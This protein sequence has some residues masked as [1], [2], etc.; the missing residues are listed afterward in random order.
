L[1]YVV[2]GNLIY[3]VHH[4]TIKACNGVLFVIN[5]LPTPHQTDM[6]QE[7][8]SHICTSFNVLNVGLEV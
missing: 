2:Q 5:M 8:V 4:C 7:V 1:I 3:V 6:I